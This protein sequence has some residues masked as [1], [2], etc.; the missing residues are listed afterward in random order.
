MREQSSAGAGDLLRPLGADDGPAGVRLQPWMLK[1]ARA[2]VGD[3][4][5]EYRQHGP[6]SRPGALSPE[7]FAA[8]LGPS[9]TPAGLRPPSGMDKTRAKT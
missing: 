3:Y 9:L 7:W 1:E 6:R 2:V 4:R 8:Q 5:C